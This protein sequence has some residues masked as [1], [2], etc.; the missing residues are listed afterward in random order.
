MANAEVLSATDI[1]R[2]DYSLTAAMTAE[3]ADWGLKG[4]FDNRPELTQLALKYRVAPVVLAGAA[5]FIADTHPAYAKDLLAQAQQQAGEDPYFLARA[6]FASL[7]G[8]SA[9]TKEAVEFFKTPEK[10]FRG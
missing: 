5:L 8:S 3:G 10:N 9:L 7:L 4:A 6:V 2:G 1:F